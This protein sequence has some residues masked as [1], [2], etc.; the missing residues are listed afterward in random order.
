[1]PLRGIADFKRWARNVM[2]QV[3]LF[4][5][6]LTFP[7]A[8]AKRI[9]N[10]N[11]A[12]QEDLKL[13]PPG[14]APGRAEFVTPVAIIPDPSKY[15]SKRIILAGIWKTGFEHSLLDL[16]NSAQDFGIWVD[17]DWRKIDQPMGDF[18][19]RGEGKEG[20]FG[21]VSGWIYDIAG[22]R[23]SFPQ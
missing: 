5:V 16:E 14:P 7:V 2:Q 1:M 21:D 11:L 18:S 6:L 17:A 22:R 13:A 8:C 12:Q 4:L 9:P 19:L 15:H 23:S 20:F 3:L 10:A